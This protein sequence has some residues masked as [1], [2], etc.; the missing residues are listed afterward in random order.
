MAKKSG[1]PRT[2]RD[3]AMPPI[4]TLIET[5][6]EEAWRVSNLPLADQMAE[7]RPGSPFPPSIPVGMAQI[8]TS[9]RGFDAIGKLA[10]LYRFEPP[11]LR[12][13]I[14]KE[15]YAKAALFAIGDSIIGFPD[16][17]LSTDADWV[18]PM[19]TLFKEKLA[20][21]LVNTTKNQT[22]YI[23][24]HIFDPDQ[25][26]PA[27]K[28]GPVTFYPRSDWLRSLD[29]GVVRIDLIRKVWKGSLSTEELQKDAFSGR[30]ADAVRGAFAAVKSVGGH[31]WVAAV[32]VPDHEPIQS[33]K[34]GTMLVSLAMDVLSLLLVPTDSARLLMSGGQHAAFSE[35]SLFS[36]DQGKLFDRVRIHMHGLGGP[37]GHAKKFLK[38]TKKLLDAAGVIIS[39]YDTDAASGR[40]SRLVERWINALHWYGQ[41]LREPSDFMALVKYGCAMD[42]LTDGTGNL[43]QL[44]ART[45]A[46]FGIE[47]DAVVTKDGDKLET[48]ISRVFNEGRSALAHGS[49]FGVLAEKGDQRALA[50]DL[51]HKLLLSFIEPL[52]AIIK[53]SH[54]MLTLEKDEV[55]AFAGRLKSFAKGTGA[56]APAGKRR[57]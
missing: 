42:I 45:A 1:G 37:P 11:S 17:Q 6:V 48:I 56:K 19:A 29:A 44:A 22:Q 7:K 10:D 50:Y 35:R 57:P 30:S 51:V 33:T 16:L 32:K 31:F 21:R 46:A 47:P 20:A 38:G 27:F 34:K 40:S 43:T 55:R 25:K 14:S 8:H 12:N 52:A 39:R 2:A 28:I 53:E 18:A 5:I 23:P 4:E 54:A 9:N 13:R 26:V 3:K 49:D 36:N 24:C 41:A 15:T